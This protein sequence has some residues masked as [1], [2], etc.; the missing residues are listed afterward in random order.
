MVPETVT[1]TVDVPIAGLSG[2][3]KFNGQDI[4][5]LDFSKISSDNDFQDFSKAVKSDRGEVFQFIY[6]F[7]ESEHYALDGANEY[8]NKKF[9]SN[10]MYHVASDLIV[11]EIVVKAVKAD[12]YNYYYPV[13]DS[14]KT[15]GSVT[16]TS[17][18]Y[19]NIFSTAIGYFIS[20]LP[21][22][23]IP[24]NYVAPSSLIAPF[25]TSSSLSFLYTF[26]EFLSNTASDFE[27]ILN[28]QVGSTN[29][30]V[31]LFGSGFL[32]YAGWV[33]IKFVIPV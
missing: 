25:D 22:E 19:Y 13:A 1:I 20:Y 17:S 31:L 12:F 16:G 28:L 6:G 32:I 26:G 30:W 2:E 11:G 8:F 7:V 5:P 18:R 3:Y 15:F 10:V 14:Y 23:F 21:S 9:F 29:L 33:I 4:L 24:T 27:D